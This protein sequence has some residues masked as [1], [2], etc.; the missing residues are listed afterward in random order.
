[1][2]NVEINGF[3]IIPGE[4]GKSIKVIY[5]GRASNEIVIKPETNNSITVK[6]IKNQ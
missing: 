5:I 4:D 2:E 1:M 3:L 6:I